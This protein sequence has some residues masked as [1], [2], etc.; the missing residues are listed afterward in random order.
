MS[1]RELT[2]LELVEAFERESGAF[3]GPSVNVSPPYPGIVPTWPRLIRE[4]ALAE[5]KRLL[6]AA[7]TTDTWNDGFAKGLGCRCP[8]SWWGVLPPPCPLH[9]PA[10]ATIT[11]TGTNNLAAPAPLDGLDRLR[12]IE[13]AAREFAD[14]LSPRSHEA[15]R[16]ALRDE[17]ETT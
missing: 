7:R 14:N 3:D 15:L 16:A 9:N 5:D 11:T 17:G 2:S 8:K 12:K 13:H 6:D 4:R 10:Q 1:D